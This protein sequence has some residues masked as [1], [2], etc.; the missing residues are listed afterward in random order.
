MAGGTFAVN[1]VECALVWIQL[2]RS[3]A[4]AIFLP[5]LLFL[6]RF[7]YETL[8]MSW[9]NARRDE[10]AHKFYLPLVEEM[11][12]V[13]TLLIM[14]A[15]SNIQYIQLGYVL[16]FFNTVQLMD[17]S[18]MYLPHSEN[19][20][21]LYE[22]FTHQR[23]FESKHANDSKEEM[24]ALFRSI[25]NN[26]DPEETPDIRGSISSDNSDETLIVNKKVSIASFPPTFN[27]NMKQ[28]T[29]SSTPIDIAD[30]TNTVDTHK[31]LS[32]YKSCYDFVDK[33]YSVSPKNTYHLNTATAIAA[34]DSSV[35][36]NQEINY[37]DLLSS[38]ESNEVAHNEQEDNIDLT[39]DRVHTQDTH[40]GGG[41][42]GNFKYKFPDGRKI[43]F[44]G[45]AGFDYSHTKPDSG[46]SNALDIYESK[47]SGLV[48]FVNWFSWL[49]PQ[50]L[51]INAVQE[52]KVA[53][54]N[55]HL[56][57]K[58]LSTYKI[59]NRSQ[60]LVSNSASIVTYF[61]D[62][63]ANYYDTNVPVNRYQNFQYFITIF[64]DYSF[65]DFKSVIDV[66]PLFKRFGLML[67]EFPICYDLMDSINI[68]S[69]NFIA[70][71]VYGGLFIS[72]DNVVPITAAIIIFVV[73]LFKLNY[74]NNSEQRLGFKIII[75][76]ESFITVIGLLVCSLLYFR[77]L[78]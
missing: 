75:L 59:N 53:S 5:C 12:K 49:F 17:R 2:V 16:I 41:G 7:S 44:G 1:R 3:I 42:G 18:S 29:E 38:V 33:L 37:N 21:K 62:E 73:K 13:G 45:G 8:T 11:I 27:M 28:Q 39:L 56:I 34:F 46:K 71:V 64:F 78:V 6:A 55:T 10:L 15:I 57:R 32:N 48:R 70:F 20:S 58:R 61:T 50:F 35:T 65:D 77:K 69:W 76:C 67:N 25:L 30:P 63:Q 60:S 72:S 43:E 68:L 24:Q 4:L 19:F 9:K 52:T 22:L 23:S 36:N 74:L 40:Y 54:E 47:E 51:P 31:I 26:S 14:K 66:P